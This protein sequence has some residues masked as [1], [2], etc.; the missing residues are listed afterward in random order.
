MRIKKLE[1]FGFKS[2][3][4]RTQILF[5]EGITGIV[6]PNGCGKSN[7]VDALVWV[8]GEMSAKHLR[9]SSMSD[10]IFAGSQD[11]APVGMAE[12]SLTL[13]NDGGPFPVAYMKLSEIMVTRRLHRSGESEYLINKEPARLRDIHEIFMDTG[14]GSRGFSI[15]E[16]GQIG[17]I[18]TAKP[19]DRRNLIEEAAGITKFKARKKESLRK[20]GVTEQNL[21][22]L[23]DIITELEKQKNRLSRQASRAEKYK[24]IKDEVHDKEMWLSSK[25]YIDFQKDLDEFLKT[26]SELETQTES[27]EAQ[28]SDLDN[29]RQV[30]LTELAEFE[31]A[32]SEDQQRHKEAL[33]HVQSLE[34]EIRELKFEVDQAH[35]SEEMKSD[36]LSQHTERE[37]R[38]AA[39]FKEHKEAMD[40]Q[41]ETYES[42]EAQLQNM[43]K[44]F[45]EQ[46]QKFQ[47]S[48]L[49]LSTQKRDQN[50]LNQAITEVE[51]RLET[52]AERHE[53]YASE[54]NSLSAE[55]NELSETEQKIFTQLKA[56]SEKKLVFETEVAAL[57]NSFNHKNEKWELGQKKSKELYQDYK[58]KELETTRLNSQLEAL[59]S[60]NDQ[61]EGFGQGTQKLKAWM[62]S[63]GL[64]VDILLEKL[65]IPQNWLPACQV[66]LGE[67][68]QSLILKDSQMLLKVQS[69]MRETQPGQVHLAYDFK[70]PKLD[71][72]SVAQSFLSVVSI[73]SEAQFL[74]QN[75]FVVDNLE[76][77]LDL[78]FKHSEALFVT[79]AGDCIHP[80]GFVSLGRAQGAESEL[81]SRS[82][83]VAELDKKYEEL[84]SLTQSALE[85]Y[86][87]SELENDQLK[88]EMDNLDAEIDSQKLRF[89]TTLRDHKQFEMEKM[90][91]EKNHGFQKNK[92]QDL[93]AKIEALEAEQIEL[94]QDLEL[95]KSEVEELQLKIV[96]LSET[97]ES[98]EGERFQLQSERE[99]LKLVWTR[100]DQEKQSFELGLDRIETALAVVR[101]EI[102]ELNQNSDQAARVLSENE[103]LIVE[104]KLELESCIAK[105]E[106]LEAG[107]K[108][109]QNTYEQRSQGLRAKDES[110]QI[111][112]SEKNQIR[113]SLSEVSLKCEQ[114]RLKTE[115]LEEQILERHGKALNQVANEYKDLFGDENK[116]EFQAQVSELK[117]KLSKIGDVNLSA[118]DEHKEVAERFDYLSGQK[119]DLV[120]SREQLE[121]V[122]TRIHKICKRRFQESF[123]SVNERFKK[124]F[125]VLF[126]GGEAEL[127]LVQDEKNPD[128]P[129][130]DIVAKPPGKKLQNVG[131]L[132]GGEKALTAV[133]LIFSI[134]LVKP[135][136]F[137]LLDEV[138]APL[139]DA[140]VFRF[141]DLVREMAKRSQIILVTHNKNTMAVNNK[142]YGVTMQEK[143][144]SKMV[145]VDLEG[146]NYHREASL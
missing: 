65:Q 72:G 77:A 87:K 124:V 6:G 70:A 103:K 4:D 67:R 99:E 24:V 94:N 34:N 27:M 142:L 84:K 109:K 55:M 86:K 44:Q 128:E 26:Q 122:I 117:S 19:Y 11:Y 23:T 89:D 59:R 25:Q 8:M 28:I 78:A 47:D 41:A 50:S 97:H 16:Q 66:A 104:K 126:G 10:V 9:G 81:L 68:L 106:G 49:E 95:K 69:W 132:S 130:I 1:I 30:M 3:K 48:D 98:L 143:G 141:N 7:I 13:E 119:Q 63:Q 145:S 57:K 43:E 15:I 136:P 76:I 102:E 51:L 60:L 116:E 75:I 85:L 91:F 46:D 88:S 31:S 146:D 92:L 73:P 137:C 5:D 36:F 42:L 90:A 107:L 134:F 74:F 29:L 114:I 113:E 20:L 112:F 54:K 33:D 52:L 115:N 129:G 22:R 80:K 96:A 100:A 144:V 110:K 111:L 79:E 135:S 21:I 39:E 108:L 131:L 71:L 121:K 139:D 35:L 83:Q 14:A 120:D 127:V 138:D 37:K 45:S 82:L 101:L 123:D 2:F 140:N 53:T 64:E 133:S 125:P 32:V 40:L 118:I 61:M 56:A 18:I 93:S 62:Q 17:K 58:D 105:S 12:V 38:L